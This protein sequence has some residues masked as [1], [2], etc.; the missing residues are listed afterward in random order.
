MWH[1]SFTVEKTHAEFAGLILFGN[2]EKVA[3]VVIQLNTGSQVTLSHTR[4]MTYYK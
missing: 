4:L 2:S 3:D 1:S